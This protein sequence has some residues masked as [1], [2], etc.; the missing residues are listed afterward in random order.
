MKSATPCHDA[1]VMGLHLGLDLLH[2]IVLA[3]QSVGYNSGACEYLYKPP[4]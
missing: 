2:L 1:H 3:A 4:L